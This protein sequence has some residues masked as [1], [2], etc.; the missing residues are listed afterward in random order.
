M[1][2]LSVVWTSEFLVGGKS[3]IGQGFLVPNLEQDGKIAAEYGLV[4]DTGFK[5]PEAHLHP[6][7]R[8]IPL[9]GVFALK[10]SFVWY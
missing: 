3:G 9:F 6:K 5:L 4:Q 1:G 8:E 7:Y 2:N 10:F